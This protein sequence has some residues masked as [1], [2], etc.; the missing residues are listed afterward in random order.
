MSLLVVVAVVLGVRV[1]SAR[2]PVRKLARTVTV[3]DVLLLG[4][5]VALLGFHCGAMFF[6]QLVDWPPAVAAAADDIRA[7]GAASVVWYVVPAVLVLLGLRRQHLVGQGAVAVA[8]AAVGVTMFNG[9]SLQ[10]HLVAI[11]VSVVVLVGVTAALLLPPWR[12]PRGQLLTGAG[13]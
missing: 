10:A 5:G 8:L 4:V 12:R 3:A 6:P 2:L 11:F 13:G 9:G 1:W 7:L